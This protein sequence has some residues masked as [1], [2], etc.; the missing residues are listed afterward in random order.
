[1]KN[2]VVY[3]ERV[4]DKRFTVKANSE[5][6]AREKVGKLKGCDYTKLVDC[7]GV[8]VGYAEE[9]VEEYNPAVDMYD[10]KM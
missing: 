8:N 3:T 4:Y 10:E 2:Y 6:E 1:M 7:I 5:E 9:I